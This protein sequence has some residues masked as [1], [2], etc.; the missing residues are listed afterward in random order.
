MKILIVAPRYRPYGQYYEL[1][2]GFAYIS[3]SFKARGHNV[4]FINLNDY[5]DDKSFFEA[6]GAAEAIFTG[7]LSVHYRQVTQILDNA[8]KANPKILCVV[9]GGLV[10]S[11]PSAVPADISVIGEGELLDL[12]VRG[13]VRTEAIKKLDDLPFPDYEG[14]GVRG[15]LDRQLC[16]DEHYLYPFDKPRCLPII[17]SRSCPHNCSFCFHPLGKTYRQRS[18][19][20]F[21]KEVE[22][23][24]ETYQV[25]MLGVLDELISARPDRL[26][27]FC[28]RIQKYRINWMTQMRAD[29]ITENTIKMLKASG[30]FQISYGIESASNKILESMNKHT[31]IEKIG[32][33]LEWTYDAGI[34]IQGNFI[35]GDKNETV[36][37]ARETLA[38][39][40][41]N[42]KFM[43]NLSYIIPYPGCDLYKHAREKGL[44]PNEIEYLKAG[45]PTVALTPEIGSIVQIVE[46]HKGLGIL[47]GE[48]LFNEVTGTDKHRGRLHHVR[49]KCPHCEVIVEY[50]NLY[51]GATNANMVKGVYRIGCRNCNQRFDIPPL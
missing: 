42:R 18:L 22:Y 15:Y 37:T 3:S 29:S 44:I 40:L 1:P 30:C 49:V 28:T 39:W 48:L 2:L 43:I 26:E 50:Q 14:L 25:N 9:G 33:A 34:G 4:T 12:N 51:N 47:Y 7:G 21:F 10:S 16:G 32:Q 19:D 13:I 5:T 41:A 24:I 17:S 35:F 27:E 23:L 8:R 6:I 45:C 36:V 46:G 11:N 31:T 38:W 20:D